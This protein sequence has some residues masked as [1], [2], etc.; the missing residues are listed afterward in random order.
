MDICGL[1]GCEAEAPDACQYVV[2]GFGPCEGFR[3]S[4]GGLDVGYDGRLQVGR[5][6]MDATPDLLVGQVGEE[7]LHL[8][9]PGRRCRGEMHLPP[10]SFGEPVPNGL[11]LVAGHVVHDD[12]DFEIGWHIGFDGVQEG[13]EFL[14]AMTSE[15]PTDDLAGRRVEGR[16]QR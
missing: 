11:G 2:G 5:G 8:I 6:A 7:P 9:D 4:I 15:T 12:V 1:E 14:G 16:K 3:A 13:S 10:R